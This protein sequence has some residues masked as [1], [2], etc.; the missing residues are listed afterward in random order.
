MMNSMCI[1]TIPNIMD[2]ELLRSPDMVS[3]PAANVPLS[4][5]DSDHIYVR[6]ILDY[7]GSP[8]QHQMRRWLR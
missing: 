3:E 4:A 7:I 6:G 8:H 2:V 5:N 1:S